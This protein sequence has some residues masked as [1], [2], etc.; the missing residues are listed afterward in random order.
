MVG[1]A[2]EFAKERQTGQKEGIPG[3]SSLATIPS[4]PISI[5]LI[6]AMPGAEDGDLLNDP[7]GASQR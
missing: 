7:R 6:T 1:R 2:D 4:I 3:I 5:R